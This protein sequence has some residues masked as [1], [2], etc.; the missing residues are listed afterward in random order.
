MKPRFF[1]CNTCGNVVVKL[2]DSGVTPVCCGQ[3][4]V[5]L[6]PNDVE[7]VGEKHLPVISCSRSGHVSVTV[8]ASQHPMTE[9]HYIRFIA[10][11]GEHCAQ[12]VYLK[13]G[14]QPK[15]EFDFDACDTPVAVYAYCNIH[16]LWMAPCGTKPKSCKHK[17]P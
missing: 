14:S 10:V 17:E 4:M 2:I 12:I 5:E 9:D 16:G 15:A 7:G 3:T 6:V 11:V 1:Y 13:P 8:G